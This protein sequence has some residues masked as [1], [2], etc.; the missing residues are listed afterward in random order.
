LGATIKKEVRRKVKIVK[1]GSN[2]IILVKG[3][4]EPIKKGKV[5]V[6]TNIQGGLERDSRKGD[7]LGTRW[8]NLLGFTEKGGCGKGGREG[9][10]KLHK[11]T[12][13][14]WKKGKDGTS[15]HSHFQ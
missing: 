10:R 6:L 4:K 5:V 15:A 7:R 11:Q 12:S 2:P 8:E 13:L 3:D 9:K 1:R 14:I